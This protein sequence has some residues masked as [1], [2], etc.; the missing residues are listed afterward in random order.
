MSSI[1]LRH[2]DMFDGP[3]DLIV[4][5]C[6]T[7]GTI[8]PFVNERLIHYNIPHP[9]FGMSLGEIQILPFEGAE[10]IAQFVAFAASVT[11]AFTSSL[12]CIRQIGVRLGQAT[13][14]NRAVRRI[15]A[16][17]L[18]SGAGGLPHEFVLGSLRDGFRAT[19]HPDSTLTISVLDGDVFER[20][21]PRHDPGQPTSSAA[22]P[23]LRVFISYCH[24]SQAEDNWIINLATFL[25]ETESKPGSMYGICGEAWTCR[26]S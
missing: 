13:R 3:S 10:N 16:P 2:G 12:D 21:R 9:R 19:A 11:V 20:L 26:N 14:Q 15:T 4:L 17:L 8:T 7:V 23:P 6:S 18:G 25:R 5:P 1:E 24:G 22:A